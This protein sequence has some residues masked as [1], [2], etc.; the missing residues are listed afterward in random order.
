MTCVHRLAQRVSFF[1]LTALFFAISF[2]A[3]GQ[4]DE[5]HVIVMYKKSKAAKFRSANFALQRHAR[6]KHDLHRV[7]GLAMVLSRAELAKLR[8]DPDVQAIEEDVLR[9]PTAATK[10][11]SGEPYLLGQ[12]VPYG[13]K[14]VQAD[15]L[16]DTHTGNRMVCVIDSGY[17]RSHEDLPSGSHITGKYDA[18]TGWWYTD[19]RNHGTHVAGTIVALN[20]EGTGTVGIAPSG[21]LKLHIVKVFNANGWAYSSTLAAAA[22]ECA[23]AGA[24]VINMSIGGAKFSRLE[25]ETF[26]ALEARGI[27]LVSTAGNNGS[28]DLSYPGGYDSV[29]MVGAVDELSLHPAFSQFNSKVELAAPG[30]QVYST[31]PM[32]EGLQASLTVP[33]D[34]FSPG[35]MINS[36]V[37]AA[38]AKVADFGLGDAV[39]NTMTG[40]ICLIARGALTFAK[41]V[42]NCQASGGIGAI[43]FNSEV[44]RFDGNLGDAPTT[45]PAISVSDTEGERL[46]AKLGTTVSLNVKSNNYQTLDGTSMAAPHVAGVAALVWSYFPA[47]TGRHIRKALAATAKSLSPEGRSEFTGFGIVQ[48]R[49]AY[50]YLAQ[51]G[52]A[53]RA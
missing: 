22:E 44:G 43:I 50:D 40:K 25:K 51:Y 8:Q 7:G 16:P 32:G 9:Y 24:N 15:Q 26:A 30:A 48:A 31:M 45:I 19:E 21:K 53:G 36:F 37:G 12:R 23:A 18:G 41:K 5:Q 42:L 3:Y 20:N 39:T 14:M 4:N 52:C 27:L 35:R 34:K 28:R 6:I 47:C 2:P 46:L 1:C 38:S 10:A 33:G 17:D 29:I 11:S 49:A 13:L